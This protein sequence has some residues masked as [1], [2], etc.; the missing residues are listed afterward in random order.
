HLL[1]RSLTEEIEIE[2][3][4]ASDLITCLADP[5]QLEQAV[6]NLAINARDAMPEG[7]RLRIETAN[8][9][10]PQAGTNGDLDVMPGEYVMIAVTD[11]GTGIPAEN[12]AQIFEPFFTT[13][14]VGKGTGL[15][16]SM[17]YGFVKQ[18]R[19]DIIVESGENTGTTFKIFLPVNAGVKTHQ[20]PE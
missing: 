11:T 6:L 13:K 3:N 18:S 9:S 2:F 19:G 16:L 10:L 17:V 5:G 15:G 4:M 14:D 20:W 1:R 7:G 12:L 8:A